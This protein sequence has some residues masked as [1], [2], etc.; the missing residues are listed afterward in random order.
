[1]TNKSSI[2]QTELNKFN[3]TKEQ[4]W[5]K[6]GEFKSLHLINPVRVNYIKEKIENHFNIKPDNKESC[7]KLNLLDVG[8]GGGLITVP[9]YKTGLH[10]T[11]LDANKQNIDSAIDYA[12]NNQLNIDYINDTVEAHVNSKNK[13]DVILCLEVLEHIANPESFLVNLN[14]LLASGGLLIMSTINRTMKSYLLAILMAEYVLGMVPKKTHDYRKFIKPSEIIQMLQC[15]HL[16]LIELK[17][18]TFSI[19]NNQWQ[20]TD[21]IDVNYFIVLSKPKF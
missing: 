17:G 19:T 5:D 6:N 8:C 18:M 4:W 14:K 12:E 11:G 7:A 16:D 9:M 1:M 2:D 20:L 15:T 10:V 21:D 3:K 13:Y